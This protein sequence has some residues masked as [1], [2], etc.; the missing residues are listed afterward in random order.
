MA[1]FPSVDKKDAVCK[2]IV[3]P[4]SR[5]IKREYFG[6]KALNIPTLIQSYRFSSPLQV[7]DSY[8]FDSVRNKQNSPIASRFD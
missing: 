2:L 8:E 7:Q 5:K 3:K 6:L 4:Y 1:D